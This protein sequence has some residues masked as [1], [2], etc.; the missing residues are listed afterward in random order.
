MINMKVMEKNIIK[1]G[2]QLNTREFLKMVNMKE[3]GNAF[4]QKKIIMKDNG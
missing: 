2:K 4:I 3:L 1:M